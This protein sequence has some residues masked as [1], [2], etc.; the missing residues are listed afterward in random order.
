MDLYLVNLVF[1]ILN[2]SFWLADFNLFS[3][4]VSIL[5]TCAFLVEFSG[6]VLY[7]EPLL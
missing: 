7:G 5:C 6:R 2:A 4:F 3:F 1:G